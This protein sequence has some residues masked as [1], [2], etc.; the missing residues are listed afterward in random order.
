MVFVLRGL[1]YSW[2]VCVCVCVRERE[3]ERENESCR[4]SGLGWGLWLRRYGR[5]GYGMM[6]YCIIVSASNVL[7]Y[8]TVY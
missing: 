3:R 6:G 8:V 2:C 4:E 1:L 5:V 7:M